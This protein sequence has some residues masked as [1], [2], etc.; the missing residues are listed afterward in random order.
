GLL[1]TGPE[2]N[3]GTLIDN[4][5]LPTTIGHFQARP[6][7]GG[8]IGLAVGGGSTSGVT[9]QSSTGA[10]LINQNYIFEYL[11][12]VDVGSDGAAVDLAST[13]ITMQP[14]LVSP[15]LVV[16][17]GNFTTNGQTYNWHVETTFPNGVA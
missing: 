4:D 16:S 11:N 2:V 5:V 3:N 17:E 12:Y 10:A 15:D 14:T 6:I 13:T 1:P 7:A 9:V 8:D